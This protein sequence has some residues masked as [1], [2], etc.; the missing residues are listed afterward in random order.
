MDNKKEESIILINAD[1]DRFVREVIEQNEY[2]FLFHNLTVIDIGCNIGTFSLWIH[3]LAKIIYAID[4]SKENIAN[5]DKTL[6]DNGISDI[7]TFNC[8]IAGSTGM[9]HYEEHGT[10]GNGGWWLT[11]NDETP[12]IQ[13]YSL[14]DF[15]IKEKIDHIDILKVDVEGFE[16]EIL[17]A[18]D[19]PKDKVSWIVGE[20]HGNSP[21]SL[22]ES[23]GYWSVEGGGD[24]KFLLRK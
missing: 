13:S 5:L 6:L 22:S 24:N 17:G 15:M 8:A 9:R 23:M 1:T 18:S 7:K 4:I 12:E 21:V 10:A 3:K 16:Q 11:G 14:N 20:Q 19:F 2:S